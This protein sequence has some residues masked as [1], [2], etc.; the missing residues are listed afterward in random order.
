MIDEESVESR[1]EERNGVGVE[2]LK[3]NVMMLI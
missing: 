3:L 2:D 1:V